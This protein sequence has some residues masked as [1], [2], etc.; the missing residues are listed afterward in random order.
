MFI[1]RDFI[2][3]YKQTILGPLWFFL[4]PLLT[5]LMF[6][7]IFGKI[8]GLSTEGAPMIL[9]YLSGITIWNYFS[10]TLNK[11]AT[12]LKDNAHL[13]GK[14]Y[15]PRLT[16]PI[17][18]VLSNLIRFAIQ[19]L[20]FVVVLFYYY[21]YSSSSSINPNLYILITP[22][23]VFLMGLMA[24]GIGLIISALTNK[25]KDLIFLIS[26]GIQLLMFATPVI[27]P[28]STVPE[29]YKAFIMANP[30]TPIVEA[31]R[32]GF[33]GTGY[34]NWYSLLYSFCCTLILILTGTLIFNKVERN[35]MD[36]V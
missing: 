27:Y 19:F 18:I 32:Y 11:T 26:F 5:T 16:L 29:K 17:S 1:H 28:L 6:S 9:F 4:Q 21:R 3:T 15:F 36:T 22:L 8:A 13:F 20:L 2:A 25:Y 33:L 23:L 10:E 7:L 14:I 31:F 12:V 34:F 24:L 35:F 30:L